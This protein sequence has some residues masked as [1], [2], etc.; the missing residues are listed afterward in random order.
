MNDAPVSDP[1]TTHDAGLNLSEAEMKAAIDRCI[2]ETEHLLEQ[3]R[4]D[5]AQAE[6]SSARRQAM[7]KQLKANVDSLSRN[8]TT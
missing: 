1:V 2:A 3:M 6:A 7:Q 8:P 5:D 4:L